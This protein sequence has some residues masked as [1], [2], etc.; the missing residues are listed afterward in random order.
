MKKKLDKKSKGNNN[1]ITTEE[2][3]KDY[4]L[5][6]EQKLNVKFSPSVQKTTCNKNVQ[7]HQEIGNLQAN[8]DVEM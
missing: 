8:A 1:Q 6:F 2:K 5:F 4:S 3:Y 7:T